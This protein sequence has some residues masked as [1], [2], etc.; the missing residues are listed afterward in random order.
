MLHDVL[1]MA[2][3]RWPVQAPWE[4]DDKQQWRLLERAPHGHIQF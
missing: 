1:D 4:G 3:G 2:G